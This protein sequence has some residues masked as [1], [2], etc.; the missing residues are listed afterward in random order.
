MQWWWNCLGWCHRV[1][2][3]SNTYVT[4][5]YKTRDFSK[6]ICFESRPIRIYIGTVFVV[7]LNDISLKFPSIT[8]SQIILPFQLTPGFSSWCVVIKQRINHPQFAIVILAFIQEIW[9]RLTQSSYSFMGSNTYQIFRKVTVLIDSKVSSQNLSLSSDCSTL[10]KL[11]HSLMVIQFNI[12][13]P[14]TSLCS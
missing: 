7:L 8:C 1:F 11:L 9:T 12:V 3:I 5:G 2:L 4:S 14:P 10:I 13:H 6:Y